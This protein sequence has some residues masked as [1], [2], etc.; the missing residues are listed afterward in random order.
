MATISQAPAR[1]PAQAVPRQKVGWQR[2]RRW[3]MPVAGLFVALAFLWPYLV[4]L[5][6]SLRPSSDVVQTPATLL[7]RVWQL[8]TYSQVRISTAETASTP[9][10]R[11]P[12]TESGSQGE[13]SSCSPRQI[14]QRPGTQEHLD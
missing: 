4:M 2:H 3:V 8:S 1:V 13:S 14:D 6:N 12:T 7:P 9:G 11:P 10:C 5:L